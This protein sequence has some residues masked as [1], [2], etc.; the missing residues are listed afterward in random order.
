METAYPKVN[1][2]LSAT[3]GCP[4][5]FSLEGTSFVNKQCDNINADRFKWM[6]SLN[7]MKTIVMSL[8]V[9]PDR[10]PLI[11]DTVRQLTSEGYRVIVLGAGP[12]YSEDVSAI[13]LRAGSLDAAD[14]NARKYLE[15]DVFANE[16]G[17]EKDVKAA[18]GAYIGKRA[19]FCGDG[20]C[21]LMNKDETMPV[22]FDKHHLTHEAAV[23]FGQYLAE[24]H[25]NLFETAD[26]TN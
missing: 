26:P 7:D 15:Q 12:T 10:E 6:R 17:F 22:I 14:I 20:P 16:S 3:G 19:F 5:T 4:P 24:K 13:I 8:R 11:V 18:G 1:F 23:E 9:S 21:R 25:P 2:L